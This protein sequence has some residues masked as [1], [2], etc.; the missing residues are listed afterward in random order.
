M[1]ESGRILLSGAGEID[2]ELTDEQ[3]LIHAEMKRELRAG[4]GSTF[5]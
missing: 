1:A 4:S 5:K 3:R 2:E